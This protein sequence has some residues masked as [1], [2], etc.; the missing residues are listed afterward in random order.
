MYLLLYF[1]AI[2][3]TFRSLATLSSYKIIATCNLAVWG[4]FLALGGMPPFLG[5][6][7]KVG[8]IEALTYS[9]EVPLLICLLA[10][11]GASLYYY[12]RV[13]VSQITGVN[14][15]NPSSMTLLYQL[16]GG[17]AIGGFII[18]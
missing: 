1:L 5:F 8:A 4:H 6:C 16:F 2:G 13:V 14:P 7:A 12:A 11:S 15:H 10:A 3:L 18:L 17:L 9:G